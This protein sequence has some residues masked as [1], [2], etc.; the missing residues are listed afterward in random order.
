MSK[1]TIT[2]EQAVE[3]LSFL[4]EDYLPDARWTVE[5][6]FRFDRSL[7][8]VAR[9]LRSNLGIRRIDAV[10]G[11]PACLWSLDWFVQRRPMPLPHYVELLETYAQSDMGVVLVFDNPFIGRDMLDEPYALRLLQ[12]LVDRDRVRKNAVCVASDTLAQAIRERYPKQRLYCHPNRLVVEMGRRTPE[13]YNRLCGLYDR[14]AL[15]PTDASRPAV[16]EKIESPASC[17]VVIND[18]LLRVNPVRRNH[19]QLLSAMRKE[20]YDMRHTAH[21][22][23][24]L[25]RSGDEQVDAKGLRQKQTCVLTKDE[26]RRLYARGFRSFY[27]QSQQFRNEMTL[28]WDIFQ[29][30]FGDAPEHTNK[31]ALIAVSAMAEFGRA[32]YKL[33][34]GLSRFS[35]SN[36]E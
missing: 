22:A 19:L 2:N 35:F 27:I 13:L 26:A 34:S 29:C 23:E 20:P 21:R 24:L 33:P 32:E 3:R 30:L 5:G 4:T 25:A 18:S 17:D 14:V 6:A 16:F 1:E 7:L 28:L 15:H 9:F 8:R 31:Y 12:E 10:A 11:C 36:Y